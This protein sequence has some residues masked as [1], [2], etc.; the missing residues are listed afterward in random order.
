MNTLPLFTVTQH[1]G[2]WDL[3]LSSFQKIWFYFEQ[4]KHINCAKWGA[5]YLVGM[6]MLPN[7]ILSEFRKDI[8]L[9]K[10]GERQ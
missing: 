2:L 5:V 8:F 1:G 4:H 10:S 9:V 6:H 7:E 3:S